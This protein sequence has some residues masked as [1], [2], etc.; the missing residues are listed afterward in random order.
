MTRFMTRRQ[1]IKTLGL[2]IG[3]A[4]IGIRGFSQVDDHKYEYD[5][6]Y[7]D[8]YKPIDNPLN[9]PITAITCGAGN[10]GNV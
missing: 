10:R 2:T 3:A 1:A 5:L 7:D 9:R 4:T 6:N 8:V